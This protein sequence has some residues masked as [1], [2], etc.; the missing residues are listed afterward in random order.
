MRRTR[1]PDA[2]ERT[3][4]G[5]TPRIHGIVRGRVVTAVGVMRALLPDPWTL[6]SLAD[7]VHLSRSQPARAFDATVGTSPMA[8]LC[9]MRAEQ[10]TRHR[11]SRANAFE[12]RSKIPGAAL[13]G[14]LLPSGN[15]G[16]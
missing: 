11:Q 15:T 1:N 3:A 6:N 2:P 12:E 8:F 7:E 10:M 13:S 9:K 16:R 5:T 4:A 14:A